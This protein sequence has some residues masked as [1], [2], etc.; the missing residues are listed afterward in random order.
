MIK[1]AP[2]ILSADFTRLGEEIASI[3]DAEYLHFDV[4]DG[5]FV[6]NISVG[7]PVL[8]AVRK[9]TDMTLDVHLM[10]TE[11]VRYVKNFIDAGADIVVIHVEAD[12]PERTAEALKVIRASGKRAGLSL[13]PKTPVDAVLPYLDLLDLILVMTVEPGFGGQK[14]MADQLDKV[15]YL[16]A[17]IDERG[18]GCEIEVDGGINPE[19]AKLCVDAGVDVL[20]AGSAVF[21]AGDRTGVIRRLRCLS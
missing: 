4:M 17:R 12:T 19:T 7:I 20:V 10:I 21:G 9:F 15:R 6:P 18:L 5:I 8:E 11:P 2:S 16:R 14:F 13:K 3:R 1:I